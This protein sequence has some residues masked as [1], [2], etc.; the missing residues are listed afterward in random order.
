[1][2]ERPRL[3]ELDQGSRPCPFGDDV[4]HFDDWASLRA[5]ADRYDSA[6]NVVIWWDWWPPDADDPGD[7]ITLYVA[8]PNRER[9]YPWSAPVA[10]EEEPEIREWLRG[11]LNRLIGYWQIGT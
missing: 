9:V 10:R 1:M 11:R 5:N 4:Q 6:L 8:M 2:G 7:A 3:W